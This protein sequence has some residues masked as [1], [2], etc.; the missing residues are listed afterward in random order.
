MRNRAAQAIGVMPPIVEQV[1]AVARLHGWAIGAHGSMLRDIDLIAVPWT[2]EAVPWRDMVDAVCAAIG[3]VNHPNGRLRAHG[4]ISPLLTA[5][6]AESEQERANRG[7]FAG[8]IHPKGRWF[9]PAIDLS[10]IDP[11]C[12]GP[13]AP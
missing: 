4:R 10:I 1:R 2:A 11:R 6:G 9:P 8:P 5:I 13:A 12:P 7:D 3:Y